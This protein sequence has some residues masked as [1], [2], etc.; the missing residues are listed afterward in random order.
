MPPLIKIPTALL[1]EI[2]KRILKF[3]WLSPG[4][5]KSHNNLEREER[6]CKTLPD[7]KTCYKV[8]VKTLRTGNKDK[9]INQG[10]RPER[11]EINSHMYD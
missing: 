3:T 11:P 5:P 6:G 10:S 8:I 2:D 9:Y 4:T 7:F 1:A